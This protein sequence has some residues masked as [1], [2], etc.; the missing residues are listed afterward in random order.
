MIGSCGCF[1][2]V[3]SW[4]MFGTTLPPHDE[5]THFHPR[6]PHG[7]AKVQSSWITPNHRE[8]VFGCASAS[9]AFVL[10]RFSPASRPTTGGKYLQCLGS[11]HGT[12]SM[13]SLRA[14]S[15]NGNP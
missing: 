1:S 4:E 10:T 14:R 6:S 11:S 12:T 3:N 8:A 7:A 2:Q 15:A 9:A 13:T 5:K